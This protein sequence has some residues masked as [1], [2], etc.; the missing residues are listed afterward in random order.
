MG[1][2]TP[3]PPHDYRTT[4]EGAAAEDERRR[5]LAAKGQ[6]TSFFWEIR[7]LVVLVLTLPWRVARRLRRLAQRQSELD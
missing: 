4:I 2:W 6:G 7:E 5:E 1:H 3:I